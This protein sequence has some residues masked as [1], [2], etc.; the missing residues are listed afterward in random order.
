MSDKKEVV[1]TLEDYKDVDK[2]TY[3]KF[4]CE[5]SFIRDWQEHGTFPFD[6]VDEDH[7]KLK[8]LELFS[9]MRNVEVRDIYPLEVPVDKPRLIGFEDAPSDED[10]DPT[11]N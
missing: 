4:L 9:D 8:A 6:A 3:K 11:I 5:L 10:E 2:T 1:K 7:A